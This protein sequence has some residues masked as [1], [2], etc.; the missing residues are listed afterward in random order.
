MH[1]DFSPTRL[2]VLL[3]LASTTACTPG[4]LPEDPDAF[5]PV[6]LVPECRPNNDGIIEASELPIVVGAIARVRV[7]E[8]VAV[9]VDGEVD[10][11]GITVWDLTR[12]D[13]DTQPQG[14][15]AAEEMAGQWF[16]D[17]FHSADVA[18]PLV[19]GGSQL[20]PLR[21]DDDGWKLLGGASKDED[22]PEGQT[23]IVYDVPTVLYPFPLGLGSKV[24]TTSRAQNAVLLGLPTAFDDETTVEAVRIGRVILPDLELENTL[25][26]TIRLRRTLVAGD[27]Q[28]VSHVFVHECLGEVA[29]FVSEAVPLNQRLDDDFDVAKEVWRLAL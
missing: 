14:T 27:V 25:Q 6:V 7:G 22:P 10:A 26:V 29:R 23:R 5:L 4:P 13:P 15:L 19:P 21:V 11:D 18:A 9:D 28:Q 12:P 24:V 2:L 16:A 20:G 8:N 3:A 17:L 1:S